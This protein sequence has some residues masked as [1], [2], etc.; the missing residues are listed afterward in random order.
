MK[1]YLAILI[2]LMAY[3]TSCTDQDDVDIK[4]Q[5]DFT[6]SPAEVMSGFKEIQPGNFTLEDGVKVRITAFIYDISGELYTKSEGLVNDFNTSYSFSEILPEGDYTIIATA[7]TVI[8]NSLDDITPIWEYSNEGSMN[9]L[10]VT[11]KLRDY[12]ES[13]LGLT[14][15][16]LSV[17]KP[18]SCSISLQA[19]TALIGLH[20]T[21]WW[22]YT[23]VTDYGFWY[24]CNDI[25]THNSGGSWDYSNELAVDYFYTTYLNVEKHI[26]AGNTGKTIYDY[27]ALL[28]GTYYYEGS[29]KGINSKG[30]VAS[31]NFPKNTSGA[32]IKGSMTL[33]A[34][35]QYEVNI[36]CYNETI[37]FQSQTKSQSIPTYSSDNEQAALV[38][39]LLKQIKK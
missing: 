39:D 21:T 26:N 18:M 23:N 6:V 32:T 7:N 2:G 28:P 37:S 33:S 5:V 19:A 25:M 30:E 11:E 1:K 14:E 4:Y 35:N 29:V 34:G 17:V 20:Y 3:F 13:T 31:Y 10:K 24:T 12:W 22:K 8:G 38:K 27:I 16:T 9:T 15:I 36:D